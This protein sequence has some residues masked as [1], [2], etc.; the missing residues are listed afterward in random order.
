LG[1]DTEGPVVLLRGGH[2]IT[3]P[4]Y[5]ILGWKSVSAGC[6]RNLDLLEYLAGVA[7]ALNGGSV[8]PGLEWCETA[9]HRD[10]GFLRP[11]HMPDV[12]EMPYRPPLHEPGAQFVFFESQAEDDGRRKPARL[13]PRGP[14]GLRAT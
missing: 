1:L 5:D 10:P 14:H 11:C 9:R 12:L 13:P 8:H 4:G 6:G 2:H 3:R 7:V